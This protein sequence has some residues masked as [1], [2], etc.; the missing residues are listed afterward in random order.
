MCA[1]FSQKSSINFLDAVYE[2]F[3]IKFSKLSSYI[4]RKS[5]NKLYTPILLVTAI[6]P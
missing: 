4:I 5:L 1:F 2:Y 3:T 6:L